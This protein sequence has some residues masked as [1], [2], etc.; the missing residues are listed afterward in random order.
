[1]T[2]RAELYYAYAYGGTPLTTDQVVTGTTTSM[3]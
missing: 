3:R 1:M 2:G